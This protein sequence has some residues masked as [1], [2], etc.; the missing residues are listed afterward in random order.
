MQIL[1]IER[2]VAGVTDDRFTPEIS[3]AEARRAWELHQAGAIRQ[4]FFRADEAAAV[5]MLECGDVPDARRILATLPLVAAGLIDFELI[6]LAAYPGF[7]RLFSSA[8][9]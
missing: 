7:G 9:S 6:P 8:G 2:A 5:L 4:L 1:A 3:A